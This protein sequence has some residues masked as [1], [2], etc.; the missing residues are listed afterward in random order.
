MTKFCQAG[1]LKSLL[2][3]P[4]NVEPSVLD[5]IGPILGP[6]LAAQ[7]RGSL[8]TDVK[9]HETLAW[10][11]TAQKTTQSRLGAPLTPDE[12]RVLAT[13]IGDTSSLQIVKSAHFAGATYEAI[14]SQDVDIWRK[15]RNATVLYRSRRPSSSGTGRIV[16]IVSD[17]S[18]D[19]EKAFAIVQPHRPLNSLDLNKDP[20]RNSPGLNAFLVYESFNAD[21]LEVIPLKE[22]ICH[23]ARAHFRPKEP[24]HSPSEPAMVLVSLDRVSESRTHPSACYH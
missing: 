23:A 13:S 12:R 14:G 22:I 10:S 18:L 6:V 7:V 24:E 3:Q 16:R 2:S 9:A 8:M 21:D 19:P 20:Y 4:G 1:N 11:I 17:P 15:G 5:S